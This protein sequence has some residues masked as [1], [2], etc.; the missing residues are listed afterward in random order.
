MTRLALLSAAL[1]VTA[2]GAA[3]AGDPA[4]GEKVFAD[5]CAIC[6]VIVS[7][8][9]QSIVTGGDTGPNQ[10]GLIGR[11][12]GTMPAFDGYGDTLVAAGQAGLKWS[13]DEIAAYLADPRAY[14][15]DKT[16]DK[17]ARSK[18]AFKLRDEKE[19]SDVAAYLARFN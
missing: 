19:R 6:H 2:G 1:L 18:M 16:G 4:A 12:A 15:R 10:Y 13:E 14:L 8:S 7:P 17:G 11:T 3:T 5:N 9:G